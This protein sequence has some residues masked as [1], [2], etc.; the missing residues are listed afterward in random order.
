[1]TRPNIVK[2]DGGIHVNSPCRIFVWIRRIGRID[3]LIVNSC[4]H[5]VHMPL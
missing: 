1:M 2:K 5:A 3:V 4:C